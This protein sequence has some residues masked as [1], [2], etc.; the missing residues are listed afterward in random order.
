MSVLVYTHGDCRPNPGGIATAGYVIYQYNK[1]L[2]AESFVVSDRSQSATN[3]VAAY[4]GVIAA[5]YRLYKLQ[6]TFERITIYSDLAI[7]VNQ[8]KNKSGVNSENLLPLYKKAQRCMQEFFNMEID[9]IKGE[10]NIEAKNLAANAY[11][12]KA[13]NGTLKYGT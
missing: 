4:A 6:L 12:K 10:Q 5:M 3:F 1:R 9:F 2:C 11:Y 8:L 13:G 7:V